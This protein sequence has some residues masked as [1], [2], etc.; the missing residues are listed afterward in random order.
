MYMDPAYLIFAIPA[1]ILSAL[2][3]FFVKSTFKKYSETGTSSGLTGAEAASRMLSSAG[4]HNVRIERI[5]GFL[6]DH[7]DPTE[8]V[9]RLSESVYGSRSLSAIGVACHEAGH[10]IQKAESYPF[11]G[12]RSLL[13]VPANIGSRFSYIVIMAGALLQAKPLINAG[14]ILFSLSVLFTLV[15]LPVEWNASSRAKKAMV[16]AGILRSDERA[17]AGSVLNAAFLTYVAGAASSIAT[18][19]Y[20]MMRLGLLGNRNRR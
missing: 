1:L 17:N 2:A 6:S 8:N 12:L 4:I 19:L 11:M 16:T 3:S 18:L 10:A 14:L 20:Y 5:D 7:Y 9:L 13:V 15:T